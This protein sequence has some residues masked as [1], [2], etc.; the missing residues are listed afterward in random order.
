MDSLDNQK[1]AIPLMA[2]LAG[3][4]SYE[5]TRDL[6]PSKLIESSIKD[7]EVNIEQGQSIGTCLG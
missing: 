5:I 3:L 7:K 2:E 1:L 6:V 4:S